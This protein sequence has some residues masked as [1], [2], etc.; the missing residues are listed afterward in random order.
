MNNSKVGAGS[1]DRLIALSDGV[2]AIAMTLLVLDLHVD[3]GLDVQAFRSALSDLL[4]GLGAYALSFAILAAFWRDHRRILQLAHQV[5][6]LVVRLTLAGLGVVALLPFPTSM[7]ANYG[8][9]SLAVVI[10]AGTI[11]VIDV[12]HLALFLAF[13]RRPHLTHPI[14]RRTARDVTA[15]LGSSIVIFTATIPIAFLS[16]SAA[17][18]SWLALIPVRFALSRGRQNTPEGSEP[19][20]VTAEVKQ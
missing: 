8:S 5:D 13:R 9:Q 11:A 2:F 7:L 14:S 6:G 3:G 4:P 16:P 19:S 1:P 18:W 17:M 15:D 12:I 20:G 10:Y